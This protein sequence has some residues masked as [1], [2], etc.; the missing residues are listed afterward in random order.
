MGPAGPG[1][2]NVA[3]FVDGNVQ[4]YG[5]GFTVTKLGTGHYRLDFPNSEPTDF[6][7]SRR[8]STSR[9]TR[10]GPW[11]VDVFA[12]APDDQTPANSAFQFVAAQVTQ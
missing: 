10:P 1:V 11:E 2:K 9:A 5:K 6:P 3:G 12:T 8:R 7:A 4:P